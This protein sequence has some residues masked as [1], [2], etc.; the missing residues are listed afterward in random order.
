MCGFDPISFL[1]TLV[2]R[3]GTGRAHGSC[4]GP[5]KPGRPRSPAALAAVCNR[6]CHNQGGKAALAPYYWKLKVSV[7]LDCLFGTSTNRREV[8]ISGISAG[9]QITREWW[10][11]GEVDF[12]K[13][14]EI[15]RQAPARFELATPGLQD[16]CSNP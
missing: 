5:A 11:D 13:S 9:V 15:T 8:I 16:Q 3:R 2:S 14:E 12:K 1:I 10:V 7:P 6:L 4:C